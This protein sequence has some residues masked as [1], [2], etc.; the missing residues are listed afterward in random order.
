[1]EVLLT[2]YLAKIGS[3]FFFAFP[4]RLPSR[5]LPKRQHQFND[6]DRKPE[7]AFPSSCSSS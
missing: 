4:Q 2:I 7:G 5:Q 6:S 3:S 1:L